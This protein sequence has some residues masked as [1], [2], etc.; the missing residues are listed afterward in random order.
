MPPAAQ[1]YKYRRLIWIAF[2]MLAILPVLTVVR[3]GTVLSDTTGEHTVS[4]VEVSMLAL[5]VLISIACGFFLLRMIGNSLES[6]SHATTA[7]LDRLTIYQAHKNGIAPQRSSFTAESDLSALTKALAKIQAEIAVEMEHISTQTSFL[8]NLQRVL[9][10]SRDIILILDNTNRITFSNQAAR[11]KLGLLPDSNL[12]H[13]LDEGLLSSADIG[14]V[15]DILEK[16]EAAD[17]EMTFDRTNGQP[18][19]VHCVQTVIHPEQSLV[20]SKIIIMRDLTEYKHLEKQLYRSEQ[21]A[22]LGQLV[23]GVAHELNNPLTAVIGFAELCQ[24]PKISHQELKGHLALIESEANRTSHIVENLLSFSRQRCIRRGPVDIHSV[25]NRCMSLFSYNFRTNGVEMRKQFAS[26]LPLVNGDEYQLQQIFMNLIINALQAMLD[27]KTL[28]PQVTIT[29]A[30]GPGGSDILVEI[31]DSGPGIPPHV[32]PHIFDP[33]FTTKSGDRGTGLGLTVT[34]SLVL[35]HA[36]EITVRSSIKGTTFAIRFPVC[37][38]ADYVSDEP[39]ETVPEEKVVETA[40][41]K[42][43]I[44]LV[45]DEPAIL[46]MMRQG[47]QSKGWVTL[48]AASIEQA[49]RYL[50]RNTVDV[51]VCDV[52]MPDGR[53]SQLTDYAVQIQPHLAGH[54]L[55]ITGDPDA[56]QKMQAS[57]NHAPVL[58]KPF[59]INA[60]SKKIDGLLLDKSVLN[61]G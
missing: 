34:R 45:D 42:V 52:H 3:I 43:R 56:A 50:S 23:S 11:E 8:E 25:L 35:G 27:A 32:L 57:S 21:L 17:A 18:I 48:P 12:R 47:L 33:F 59:L 1:T 58:L 41:Q 13:S 54:I 49:K 40:R 37:T 20:R 14:R 55:F 22:V 19:T 60:L 9:N 46:E 4:L 31:T 2:A 36:G 39:P 7:V 51:V 28:Q 16:W 61:L 53:G 10:H 5:F 6:V 44:L 24:D 38:V 26:K 29:T 30:V 15:A